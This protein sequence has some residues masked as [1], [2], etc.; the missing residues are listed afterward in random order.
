MFT[1]VV[2]ARRRVGG[3]NAGYIA[4]FIV[5]VKRVGGIIATEKVPEGGDGF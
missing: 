1:V 4:G 2:S 3:R 5:T